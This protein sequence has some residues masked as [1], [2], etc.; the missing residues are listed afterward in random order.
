MASF[1]ISNTRY[2]YLYDFRRITYNVDSNPT[3]IEYFQTRNIFDITNIVDSGGTSV[4]ITSSVNH[5]LTT[6]DIVFISN[7]TGTT[8]PD[9]IYTVTTTP[10]D[11]T[12]RILFSGFGS[13]TSGGSVWYGIEKFRHVYR[14]NALGNVESEQLIIE[15]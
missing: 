9:G 11:N 3:L 15:R 4:T 5:N 12:F 1:D 14:Y 8:V 10:T 13:Y 7:I 2:P 6:G